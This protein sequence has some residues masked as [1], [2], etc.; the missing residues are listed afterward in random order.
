MGPLFAM[1]GLA[2]N[3]ILKKGA[4]EHAKFLLGTF[5]SGG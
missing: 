4:R 5:I 2:V 1:K 3:K